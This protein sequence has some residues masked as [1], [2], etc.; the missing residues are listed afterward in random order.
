MIYAFEGYEVDTQLYELRRDGE[1]VPLEPQVF[2]VL[3][4]LLRNRDRVVTREE[5]LENV[6]PD[7]IVTESSLSSR[8]MAARKAVGD[9]G[10]DQRVIRTIHGRGFRFVAV[11]DEREHAAEERPLPTARRHTTQTS[12]GEKAHGITF[13]PSGQDTPIVGRESEAGRLR[14]YW[15]QALAGT[16]Q[17]VFVTGEAGLGKTT[18]VRA[19]LRETAAAVPLRAG[20]GQC[21]E[22]S[23]SGEPYMPVLE[24]L[25]RVCR[26]PGGEE[27]VALLARCAPTWLA[28]MPWLVAPGEREDFQARLLGTT[29]ERMLREMAEALE[30]LAAAVPL[31]L[32]LEDVHW[33]DP[34]TLD[35]LSLVA[36]RQERAHLLL[37]PTFRPADAAGY[38]LQNV[39]QELTHRG[40]AV[41]LP[42]TSLT[43]A[44]VGDY[45]TARFPGTRFPSDLARRVHQRTGGNALFLCNV[46]DDWSAQGHLVREGTGWALRAGAEEL[47]AGVPDNLRQMVTQQFARLGPEDQQILEAASAAG[48]ECPAALVAAITGRAEEEVEDRCA[49]LAGQGRFIGAGGVA[50]W[51]DGTISERYRFLHEFYREVLY[52]R[53]PA[54]RR[55]RLHQLAGARLEAGYGAQAAEV[56]VELAAHFLRGRDTGRA[57]RYLHLAAQQ[58]LRRSAYREALTHIEEGLKLLDGLPETPERLGWELSLQSAAAPA[59][60]VVKGWSAPEVDRA[61]GRARALCQRVD[62]FQG[63]GQLLC[64]LA[65][66]HEYRGEY[67]K[68]QALVEQQLREPQADLVLESHELLACS[69]FHQ[70]AFAEAVAHAEEV[71]ARCRP[72]EHSAL[73]ALHGENPAVGGN[74]WASLSL[75][76]LGCPDQALARAERALTL[77]EEESPYSLATARV[78]AAILRQFRRETEAARETAEAAIAL[79]DRQGFPFRVAQG[80]ILWGWALADQGRVDGPAILRKGL[81]AYEATGAEMGRP[82]F[83]ALL[84]E[85]LAG[86]EKPRE[87]L[88]VLEDALSL[89]REGRPFYYEAELHRLR[90]ELLGKATPPGKDEDIEACFLQALAVSRRQGAIS[91]E[92]RAATSLSH[93]WVALGRSHEA[94]DLTQQVYGRF[95]EGL[96]TPDLRRAREVL[97]SFPTAQP[98]TG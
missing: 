60:I 89:V 41:H 52:D 61:Y 6:W 91:L 14:G 83:L 7:R 30:A 1:R 25:G 45:L 3:L 63:R 8:L 65:A 68:A 9:T 4:Y 54:G 46:L 44:A 98:Q 32:V 94:R 40:H 16:R 76:F 73:M 59:W 26:A 21:L 92:L 75:W 56:A 57:V 74:N 23:G 53:V 24:A 28:Q 79:A 55:A 84:A 85:A 93:L 17:V 22:Q 37:V 36:R 50:A 77:A 15:D 43:E 20:W 51:P 42:L 47:A 18:L 29:R 38:P 11:V 71:L 96:E 49:A 19:F 27:V 13:D 35:L 82:Y 67:G 80:T 70:G 90:G 12:Q 58:A 34:S 72:H 66:V 69:H 2:D 95:T 48:A 87:G 10:R 39:A 97:D 88:A 64:G 5:L 86:H 33:A 31:F 81:A 78:Q 62:A